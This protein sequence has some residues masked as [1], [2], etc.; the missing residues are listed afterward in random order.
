M[1]NQNENIPFEDDVN[2]QLYTMSNKSIF[3]QRHALFK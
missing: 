2:I 3:D 1:N